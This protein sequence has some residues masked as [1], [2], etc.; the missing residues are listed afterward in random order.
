MDEEQKTLVIMLLLTFLVFSIGTL[1]GISASN[2]NYEDQVKNGYINVD[3][4]IY[5]V[6][7]LK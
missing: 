2:Y 7:M 4:K 3:N 5:K 6:E 1:V